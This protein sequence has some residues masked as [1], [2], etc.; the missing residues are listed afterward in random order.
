MLRI[1]VTTNA[2]IPFVVKYNDK[3]YIALRKNDSSTT[4]Y[5]MGIK[6]NLLTTSIIVDDASLIEEIA[7]PITET[8]TASKFYNNGN[9]QAYLH[10]GNYSSYA[11]PL[12]GGTLTG[13][14]IM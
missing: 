5:F 3:Y 10:A 8:S 7:G 6:L 1:P 11:L 14:L 9:P 12:T 13:K 2:L 4:F